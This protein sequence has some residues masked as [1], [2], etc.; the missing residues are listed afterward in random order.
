MERFVLIAYVNVG[1]SD[2]TGQ[3]KEEKGRDLRRLIQAA[4]NE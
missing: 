3:K 1:W 2:R 4:R